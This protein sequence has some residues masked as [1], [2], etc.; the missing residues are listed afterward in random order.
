MID[1]HRLRVLA[2][3]YGVAK[4]DAGPEVTHI[5]FMPHAPVELTKII[6]LVQKNK[7]I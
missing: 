1:V 2:K 5:T 3:S 7:N 6:E 4:V